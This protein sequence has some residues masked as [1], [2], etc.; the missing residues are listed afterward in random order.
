MKIQLRHFVVAL[1]PLIFGLAASYT[2][3]FTTLPH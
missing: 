1:L 2:F 3:A